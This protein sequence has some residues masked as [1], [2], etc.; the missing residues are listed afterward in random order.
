MQVKSK[1]SEAMNRYGN[2]KKKPPHFD[3]ICRQWRMGELS[4]RKAAG[5][6]GIGHATFL[7]W[8]NANG[9][10]MEAAKT[11][12]IKYGRKPKEVPPQF[13][14]VR[15][16]WQKGRMNATEAGRMLGV[17]HPTFLAWVRKS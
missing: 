12:G 2:P 4:A 6:L 10:G 11:R 1:G 16:E 17:S 3:S 13:E 7:T 8:V 14:F 15:E 5:K 9:Q